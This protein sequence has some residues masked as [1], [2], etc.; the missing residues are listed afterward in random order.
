VRQ[1]PR[2]LNVGIGSDE[3]PT[4]DEIFNP[5]NEEFRFTVDVAANEDNAKC[6]RF[7]TIHDDGLSQDWNG[8][9][10]WCN[11]PYSETRLWV[12]KANLSNAT[13]VMLL[14]VATDTFWFHEYVLGRADEIRWIRGRIKFTGQK[15]NAP[16]ASMIVIFRNMEMAR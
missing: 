10:V 15:F 9:V 8:E 2:L 11:P 7:Y 5:L 16:F 6:E 3:R 13:T 12:E 4:P 14:P 1:Q